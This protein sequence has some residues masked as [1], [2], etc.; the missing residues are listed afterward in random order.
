[1]RQALI[2]LAFLVVSTIGHAQTTTAPTTT[3]PAYSDVIRT[4]GEEWRNRADKATK[5][6]DAWNAF[7]A[8]C[9]TRKG[10]QPR[11]QRTEFVRVP[12]K[13]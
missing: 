12:D 11:R 4:C 9:V 1:M 10:W 6:R 8:E 2:V 13:Q 7:R 3:S 5:G